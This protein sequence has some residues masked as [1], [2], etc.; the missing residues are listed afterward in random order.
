MNLFYDALHYGLHFKIV[1]FVS[2]LIIKLSPYFGHFQMV[3][4][5]SVQFSHS[6]V[7]DSLW[8]HGLQHARLPCASPTPGACSNS[9]PLSWWCHSTISS[10]VDMGILNGIDYVDRYVHTDV[11]TF[12]HTCSQTQTHAHIL[13]GNTGL[14]PGLG[15]YP[16]EGN[17]NA[18]QYSCPENPMDRGV[19]QATVH[20]G[21]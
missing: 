5:S 10:S 9:C 16:G 20:G 14:I 3:Q 21:A 19:W 1:S 15:K 12:T 8:P 17:G 13:T 18:L 4:F 6:V 7:S 11:R 2:C